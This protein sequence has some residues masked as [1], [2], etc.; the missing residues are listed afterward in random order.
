MENKMDICILQKKKKKTR[1]VAL[2]KINIT[3]KLM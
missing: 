1:F 3:K 2:G